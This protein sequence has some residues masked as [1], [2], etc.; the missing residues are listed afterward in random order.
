[1]RGTALFVI[2]TPA[3]KRRS[4]AFQAAQMKAGAAAAAMV[5]ARKRGLTWALLLPA[6]LATLRSDEAYF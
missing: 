3:P 2:R 1:V 6:P 5:L 4:C